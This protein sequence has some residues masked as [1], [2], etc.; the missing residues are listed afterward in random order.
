M[1]IHPIIWIAIAIF[2]IREIGEKLDW[3][4]TKRGRNPPTSDMMA[5]RAGI[6]ESPVPQPKPSR[7]GFQEDGIENGI[8][9]LWG[10]RRGDLKASSFHVP[11]VD[12]I[13]FLTENRD[14]A[15]WYKVIHH[16][17]GGGVL[18]WIVSQHDCPNAVAA[19]FVNAIGP[20]IYGATEEEL[21]S[22]YLFRAI[23]V[24]SERD[25]AGGFPADTMRDPQPGEAGWP[26]TTINK[27]HRE[28]LRDRCE[29]IAR[30]QIELGQAPFYA[31]PRILLSTIPTGPS[32]RSE[33]D[34]DDAGI[35]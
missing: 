11:E 23:K 35:T 30:V 12:L 9:V 2:V 29:N 34:V 24:I 26:S 28:Q 5:L 8:E 31:I 10:R 14:Y 20:D 13:P 3:W 16:D 25:A 27:L 7:L 17:F 1:E 21:S 6:V 32:L 33:Y 18:E 22:A 19:A 15:L 4:R